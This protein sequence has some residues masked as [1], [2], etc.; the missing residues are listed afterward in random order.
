[1]KTL[2]FLLI[3]GLFPAQSLQPTIGL[4]WT[5]GLSY[6]ME[7]ELPS[8][9]IGLVYTPKKA[10]KLLSNI[11]VSGHYY[12]D[13]LNE[14]PKVN[15]NDFYVIRLQAA[16]E[17]IEFWNFTYYVGYANAFDNNLMKSFKGDFSTNFSYGFGIQTTDPYMTAEF[18][19]ESI[20]G[21]PHL[22]IGLNLNVV[23]L[24]KKK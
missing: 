13:F 15:Y 6:E 22:S 12:Y 4:H 1:M 17:F 7:H 24:L 16:K 10:N 23:N 19:F 21:Y 2:I 8:A 5:G 14:N 11:G 3:A 18:L 20:A 9:Q